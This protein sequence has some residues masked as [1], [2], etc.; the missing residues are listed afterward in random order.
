MKTR[1]QEN[2]SGEW[3]NYIFPFFWQSGG[4]QKEIVTELEKIYACGIR[5]LCVEA[6]P[7]PDYAGKRWW[8]DMD[9]I[10]DFARNRLCREWTNWNIN[11]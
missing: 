9:I 3:D 10:M 6:R 11:G 2:L 4:L 1:L 8:D 7:H 5:A